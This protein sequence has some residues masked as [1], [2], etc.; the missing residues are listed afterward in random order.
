MTLILTIIGIVAF[1]LPWGLGWALYG[2]QPAPVKVA[3]CSGYVRHF[4]HAAHDC[5]ALR[6]HVC[7]DG[8]CSYH[9][10][11]MCKCATP[12]GLR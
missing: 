8:R 7:V 12:E 3:A 9:C 1:V 11:Q 6:S 10:A 4:G 2:R 5:T